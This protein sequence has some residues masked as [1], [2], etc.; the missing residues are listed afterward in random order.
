M[1][2]KLSMSSNLQEDQL[3][4]FLCMLKLLKMNPNPPKLFRETWQEARIGST[5]EKGLCGRG[6]RLTLA[7]KRWD[8]LTYA[9]CTR[10]LPSSWALSGF[11]LVLWYSTFNL[12]LS[13]EIN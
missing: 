4:G 6:W 2:V 9:A 10:Y 12:L 7:A 1:R 13:H 5:S 11:G 8:L 3:V